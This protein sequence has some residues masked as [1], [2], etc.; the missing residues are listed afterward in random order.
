MQETSGPHTCALV[1]VV[2]P[3]TQTPV[4]VLQTWPVAQ[5]A[6]TGSQPRSVTQT[7]FSGLQIRPLLQSRSLPQRITA[8]PC[9]SAGPGDRQRPCTQYWPSGQSVSSE[10]WSPKQGSRVQRS[11]TGSHASIKRHWLELVQPSQVPLT[12]TRPPSRPPLQSAR[13]AHSGVTVLAGLP[14]WHPSAQ[15]SAASAKARLTARSRRRTGAP[16]PA[17][18]ASR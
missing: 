8:Q 17:R 2:H 1:A 13:V 7:K 16:S 10:H 6:R 14:P 9:A 4:A 5:G 15:A 11:W 3:G 12:Q 18:S